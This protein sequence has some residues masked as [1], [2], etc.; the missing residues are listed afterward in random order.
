MAWFPSHAGRTGVSLLP[1][2]T[3]LNICSGELGKPS[4]QRKMVAQ[5]AEPGRG[6]VTKS[7]P[8]CRSS[9]S[10]HAL[11]HCSQTGMWLLPLLQYCQAADVTILSPITPFSFGN[12][13]HGRSETTNVEKDEVEAGVGTQY[14][15]VAIEHLVA[16]ESCV[17][18]GHMQTGPVRIR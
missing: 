1:F 16:L 10:L 8:S 12:A 3:T 9:N 2:P 15:S 14:A 5:R 7:A 13:F 6:K 4:G 11:L 18:N 17:F